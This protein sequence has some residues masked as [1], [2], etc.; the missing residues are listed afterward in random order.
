MKCWKGNVD[1]L[2]VLWIGKLKDGKWPTEW[3]TH[4]VEGWT[5]SAIFATFI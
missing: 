3:L 2:E 1:G 5:K 4:C